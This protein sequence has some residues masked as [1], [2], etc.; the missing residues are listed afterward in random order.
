[1][2]AAM[3]VHNQEMD[4]IASHIEYTKPHTKYGTGSAAPCPLAGATLPSHEA[5]GLT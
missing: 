4:G 5:R 2:R 1:M 3:R